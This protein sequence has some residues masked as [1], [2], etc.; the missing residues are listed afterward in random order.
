[1]NGRLWVESEPGQGST[2]HFHVRVSV[3]DSETANTAP[4]D[5]QS[6]QIQ[7][8]ALPAEKGRLSVLLAEDNP[9]NQ[10]L[11]IRLLERRGFSVEL[12]TN[13]LEAL[14]AMEKHSFDVVLMDIQMPGMD[15]LQAVA[16]LRRREQLTGAHQPVI[17][18]T[19]HALVGDQERCLRAGMDAYITKP[20]SKDE[21]FSTIASVTAGQSLAPAVFE[22][23]A[24]DH[25]LTL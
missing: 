21:L 19:A 2:F 6:E 13:G 18:L 12:A 23:L 10:A 16:E 24:T 1:M 14:H 7:L 22:T 17:A 20:I 5:L 11:A 4:A 25:N 8:A 3:Q 9:V 15:G